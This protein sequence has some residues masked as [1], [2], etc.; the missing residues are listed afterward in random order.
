MGS[1]D[2]HDFQA[3][4]KP[5][6]LRRKQHAWRTNRQCMASILTRCCRRTAF[7]RPRRSSAPRRISRAWK[8][9]SASTP[10]PPRTRKP[11]GERSP[12]TALVRAVDQGSGLERAVGQVVCRRQNQSFLQLPGSPRRVVAS[13]QDRNS[14]GGRARR[15]PHS[16]LRA[17]ARRSR[18]LRQRRS[19]GSAWPRETGSRSTWAWCPS[20]PLPCS[21]AP[22]SARCT[23]SSSAASPPTPS[24][25]ASTI[26]SP[27]WS[28]RRTPP[29]GAAR[30]FR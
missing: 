6:L 12:R 20:L 9:T 25:I 19:R 22:A 5:R 14:L 29:G 1:Q 28:L 7:F 21:P 8:N 30:S 24:L 4:R 10:R 2:E 3:G 26:S 11:S 23:R 15:H 17:V 27:A 16:H 18:A 13:R